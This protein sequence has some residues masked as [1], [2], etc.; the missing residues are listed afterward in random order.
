[1]LYRAVFGIILLIIGSLVY[2]CGGKK[3]RSIQERV[4]K[5]SS[6]PIAVAPS[7]DKPI[8]TPLN[9]GQADAAKFAAAVN[10]LLQAKD[11]ASSEGVEPPNKNNAPKKASAPDQ[12]V[13]VTVTAA[14][15]TIKQYLAVKG[16]ND[17][18]AAR[19]NPQ[20]LQD[21]YPKTDS[22]R[23]D[24]KEIYWT[25]YDRLHFAA[26]HLVDYCDV[27]DLKEKNSWWPA[28]TTRE[29]VDEYLKQVL[30]EHRE[31]IRLPAAGK[32]APGFKYFSWRLSN[33][34]LQLDVGI[35]SEGRVT[36]FFPRRG[37]YVVSLSADQVRQLL[38]LVAATP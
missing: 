31:E 15:Q 32:T 35:T 20:L 9:A 8:A 5:Y 38:E 3:E 25:A 7:L 28:G 12:E 18:R 14:R 34:D 19:N 27:T 4:S 2:N 21:R 16:I 36:S 1:M 37:R 26:R 6:L 22:I 30:M 17:A 33:T 11:T 24:G 29:E 13:P 23:A 10:L